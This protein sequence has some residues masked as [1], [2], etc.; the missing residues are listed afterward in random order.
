MPVSSC[1][2]ILPADIVDMYVAAGYSTVVLTNH[3]SRHTF[4][5]AAVAENATWEEKVAF[6]LSDF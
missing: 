2:R 3:F 1:G 5:P 6:F 4:R